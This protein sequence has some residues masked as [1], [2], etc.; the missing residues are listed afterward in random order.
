MNAEKEKLEAIPDVGPVV[1]ENIHCFFQQEHN[2]D[3][4]QQLLNSGLHWPDPEVTAHEK[5]GISGLTFVVTGSLP[6]L[7]RN[8]VKDRLQSCGAKVAG[9]VSRKTDY[10]VAGEKAGSKLKKARDL[11]VQVLDEQQLIELLGS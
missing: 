11:G 10:L 5:S 2:R 7:S 1:A 8:E 4:L 3:I 6:T 9:S